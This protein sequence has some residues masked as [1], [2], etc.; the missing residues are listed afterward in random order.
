MHQRHGRGSIAVVAA[1]PVVDLAR[2]G[3]WCRVPTPSQGCALGEIIRALSGSRAR[4]RTCNT[5]D[6]QRMRTHRADPP[7][8]GAKVTPA[9]I[10][11]REVDVE[12]ASPPTGPIRVPLAACLPVPRVPKPRRRNGRKAGS[13]CGGEVPRRQGMLPARPR[14]G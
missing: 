14:S 2:W 12:M 4:T 10:E 6:V 5:G 9:L 7:R 8:A 13:R 3:L 11:R 1:P